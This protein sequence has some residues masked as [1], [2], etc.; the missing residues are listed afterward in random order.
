MAFSSNNIL[1]V[2]EQGTYYIYVK[3]AV[4]NLA[5]RYEVIV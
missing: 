3:D 2:V 4:G 1:Q 5:E